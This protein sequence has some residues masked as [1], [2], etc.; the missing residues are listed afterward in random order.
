MVVYFSIV[1]SIA[2]IVVLYVD[3]RVIEKE[4]DLLQLRRIHMQHDILKLGVR[5]VN[6][7]WWNEL[8]LLRYGQNLLMLQIEVI[9]DSDNAH[10]CE[11][12]KVKG[13]DLEEG[14]KIGNDG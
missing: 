8:W 10:K 3:S 9:D 7:A 1:T 11:I 4:N 6:Y 5:L 2:S 13:L 12:S 14:K